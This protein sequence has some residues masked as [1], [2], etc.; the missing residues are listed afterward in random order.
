MTDKNAL[1][2][3]T[4]L[5]DK[6]FP[7]NIFFNKSDGHGVLQLH[8][9]DNIEIIYLVKGNAVFYIGNEPVQARPGDILFVNSGQFHSGYSIDDTEVLYYAIVFNKTIL[10][11]QSPDP[12]H[13]KY[14]SPFLDGHALFPVKIDSEDE[15]YRFYEESIKSIISEFN[16]KK[17][18]YELAIKSYLYLITI[19]VYRNFLEGDNYKQN[20]ESY[21]QDM[22]GFKDL[23]SFID[24]HFTEKITLEQAA[25]IVH[26]SQ[27][28]FCKT[29]KKITGRTFVEFLNLYRVKEAE[30]LLRKTDLSVSTIAEKVGFCNINYFDRTFKQYKKYSPTKCR[31]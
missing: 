21:K 11:S 8:W 5:I 3:N 22:S 18:A 20:L 25:N 26:L 12:F 24:A 2:E 6:Y 30:E 15:A 17:S 28:H 16:Q 13:V 4:Y 9:H 14:V 23:L 29:F 27:Y 1:K 10:S 19:A 7:I 31:K